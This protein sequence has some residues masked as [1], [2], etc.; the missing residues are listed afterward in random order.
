[1]LIST[2]SPGT[3]GS[4]QRRST[5]DQ[6]AGAQGHGAGDVGDDFVRF[7]YEICNRIILTA[8]A[9]DERLDALRQ[10][11]HFGI[12]TWPETAECVI[13]FGSRVLRERRIP[14][15]DVLSGDV[16]HHRV[17]ENKVFGLL[18]TD[19]FAD[20]PDNDADFALQNDAFCLRPGVKNRIAVSNETA[21]RLQEI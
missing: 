18:R 19:H 4:P 11:I 8:C 5:G 14:F 13:T 15:D 16:I 3:M 1:M 21:R 6:V 7:E 17:A 20:A 9:I 12:D 2:V 10:R